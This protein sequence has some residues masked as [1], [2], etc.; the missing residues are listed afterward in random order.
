MKW[1]EVGDFGILVDPHRPTATGMSFK[2]HK[3]V[4]VAK[5]HIRANQIIRCFKS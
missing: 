3:N 4:T 5:A 1:P 2:C